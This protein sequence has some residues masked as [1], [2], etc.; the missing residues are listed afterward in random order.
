MSR[1][2]ITLVVLL[3]VSTV[4]AVWGDSTPRETVAG[5]IASTKTIPGHDRTGV[6]VRAEITIDRTAAEVWPVLMDFASWKAGV[7]G[8]EHKAGEPG[9]QDEVKALVEPNGVAGDWAKTLRIIPN[10][11]LVMTMFSP[12]VTDTMVAF[13]DYELQEIDG[14]TRV[15]YNLYGVIRL[16]G[17]SADELRALAGE[18]EERS[19]RV[20]AADFATLKAM[21]EGD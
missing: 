1:R 16:P 18:Y 5:E 20:L 8:F 11:R 19:G 2:I 14:V 13:S 3:A 10:E 17:M 15:Q 4:N 21:V 7:D 6:V 12:G 9:Q